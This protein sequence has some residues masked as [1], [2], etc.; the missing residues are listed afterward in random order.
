MIAP[1]IESNVR[2]RF[3]PAD[4]ATVLAAF[5]QMKVPPE[6]GEWAVTRARVQAAILLWGGSDL[7]KVLEAVA[8]SQIDWRDTLMMGGLGELNWRSVARHAGFDIG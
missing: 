5:A 2:S 3:A 7:A 6:E 4:A 8:G 1:T